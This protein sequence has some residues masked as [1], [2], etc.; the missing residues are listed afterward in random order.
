M[1]GL[2]RRRRLLQPRPRLGI[3][4]QEPSRAPRS[5]SKAE[6][7][8]SNPPNLQAERS[9]KTPED[10]AEEAVGVVCPE[11]GVGAGAG[12]GGGGG[13]AAAAAAAGAGAPLF[14]VVVVVVVVGAE[15]DG[16]V[17][18]GLAERERQQRPRRVALRWRQRRGHRRRSIQVQ[19]L[20]LGLP[21][22][23]SPRLASVGRRR[24]GFFR[25]KLGQILVGGDWRAAAHTS[26]MS[27]MLH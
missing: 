21:L 13:A 14:L 1:L 10:G 12:V 6:A 25:A 18:L 23:W 19:G 27:S 2:G 15:E 22:G 16:L 9:E 24:G 4:L 3:D 11:V 17:D 8:I 20:R 5:P 7:F 26:Q